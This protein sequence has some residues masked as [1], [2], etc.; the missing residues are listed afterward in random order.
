MCM[1]NKSNIYRFV[2]TSVEQEN[3]LYRHA[4]VYKYLHAYALYF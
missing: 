4:F 3:A 1:Y 2:V